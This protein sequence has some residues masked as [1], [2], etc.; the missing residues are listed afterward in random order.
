MSPVKTKTNPKRRII[1]HLYPQKHRDRQNW[2]EE[3]KTQRESHS[4]L[5]IEL[6]PKFKV[7]PAHSVFFQLIEWFSNFS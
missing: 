4:L 1:A 7:Y 5:I 6:E 2:H 3:S